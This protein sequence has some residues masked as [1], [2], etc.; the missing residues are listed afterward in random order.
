MLYFRFY[1]LCVC[2]SLV[3]M[4]SGDLE[5]SIAAEGSKTRKTPLA[6]AVTQPT[7][8]NTNLQVRL[9]I[10]LIRSQHHLRGSTELHL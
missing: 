5:D 10:A 4:V 2:I 9:I 7:L 8:C 1:D 3:P 6:N